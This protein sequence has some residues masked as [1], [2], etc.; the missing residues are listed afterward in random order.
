MYLKRPKMFSYILQNLESTLVPPA[1]E[2]Q[3]PRPQPV[4][5]L[6]PRQREDISGQCT[7]FI[8]YSVQCTGQ[9][10]LSRVYMLLCTVYCVHRSVQCTINSCLIVKCAMGISPSQTSG[11][12][13]TALNLK[14]K[15][16]TLN[17]TLHCTTFY[18]TYHN[19]LNNNLHLLKLTA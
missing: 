7:P 9:R 1:V 18:T 6:S 14:Q 16:S 10:V 11:R 8:V 3:T 4:G 5:N 2:G 15:H 12:H 13:N 19:T 17:D